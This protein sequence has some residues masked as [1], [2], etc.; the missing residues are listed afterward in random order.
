MRSPT[1]AA[2]SVAGDSAQTPVPEGLLKADGRVLVVGFS[3]DSGSVIGAG[4]DGRAHIWDVKSGE[5]IRTVE[6]GPDFPYGMT[7]APGGRLL[8]A[9]DRRQ[10]VRVV[11][12]SSG[13]VVHELTGHIGMP[14]GYVYQFSHDGSL[15][16]TS[17]QGHARLWELPSGRL[18]F[19][20][21]AG[22]GA[23]VA[24]AFSPDNQLLVGANED[25]NVRV[26][27]ARDGREMHVIDN[28]PLLTSTVE[29]SRDGKLLFSGNLDRHIYIW[30]AE[31]W[32]LVRRFDSAHPEAIWWLDISPSGRLLATGG[33]DSNSFDLPAHLVLWDVASAKALRTIRL[34]HSANQVAFSPDETVIAVANLGDGVRL[35]RISELLGQRSRNLGNRR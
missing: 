5:L 27:N 19:D 13:T 26:W 18:R 31:T 9:G 28:L 29:F 1:V 23:V 11:D 25:T 30:N 33:L 14:E 32:R 6:W 3:A 12:L 21:A 34:P 2:F 15:L 8:A 17:S 20:T 24:F 35:W 4:L 7:I 10:T 22:H 16:A